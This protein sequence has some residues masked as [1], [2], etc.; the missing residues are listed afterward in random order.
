MGNGIES[1]LPFLDYRL[2]ETAIALPESLKLRNGHGK[3]ILRE[4]MANQIP[5]N[6]RLS[7][8]KRGFDVNR[9]SWIEDSM[10]AFL[11]KELQG[12]NARIRAFIKPNLAIN[13]A[14]SNENLKR[15]NM[16]FA[17]MVSLLWLS[18]RVS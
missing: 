10:G 17:E 4:L 9:I 3:W 1:R 6:I 15:H 11:R 13:E 7:K 18:D 5:E 16:R 2:L 8:L 12:R 14:Y